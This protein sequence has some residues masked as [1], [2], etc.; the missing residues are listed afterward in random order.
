MGLKFWGGSGI[1]WVKSG[2]GGVWVVENGV[3][4]KGWCEVMCG[5]VG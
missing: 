5:K 3:L 2:V 1:Q 4:G